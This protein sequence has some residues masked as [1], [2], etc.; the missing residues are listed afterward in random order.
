MET[1]DWAKDIPAAITVCDERGVIVFM[2][3]AAGEV[4]KNRGGLGLVGKSL[5]DC[6]PEPARSALSGMLREPRVNAYTIEKD[7]VRKLIYQAPWRREGKF[8]GY[9]ELSIA[10]PGEMPH[11]V[12]G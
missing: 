5:L 6:H 10:L 12:R 3:P 7:G 8:A 4:F 1:L 2:N 11:R 9:V